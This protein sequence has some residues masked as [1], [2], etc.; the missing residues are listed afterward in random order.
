M[1]PRPHP[2]TLVLPLILPIMAASPAPSS[3]FPVDFS[4]MGSVALGGSF[5]GLDWWSES[6]PFAS[7]SSSSSTPRF[8]AEGDTV[9][10]RDGDGNYRPIGATNAGGVVAAVCW[11]EGNGGGNGT[12]F[13]AGQFEAVGGQEA[14][15]VARYDMGGTTWSAMG[16][17][18]DGQVDALYCDADNGEVWFGGEFAPP[19]G[20]SANG[21]NVA[22][23]STSS[24]SWS[25]VPFGGLDGPVHT[26]QPS[27]SSSILFGGS[28]NTLFSSSS[29]TNLTTNYPSAPSAPPN[30]STTG[31]SGYLTPVTLPGASSASGELT[32]TAGP[33]SDDGRYNNPRVLLCPGSG[34]WLAR[35]GQVSEVTLLGYNFWRATGARVANGLVEGRGTTTFW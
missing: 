23:W 34:T 18:L 19:A 11:L 4:K 3:L 31:N 26:I 13:A 24:S 9:F 7:A 14:A 20:S 22:R 29:S 16:D 30:T 12:V 33:S 2:F 25:S 28:F 21:T 6:S 10:I 1:S 15:N 17:G 5:A 32:I 8:S 27:S 35:E